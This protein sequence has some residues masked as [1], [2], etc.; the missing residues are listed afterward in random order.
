MKKGEIIKNGNVNLES[1][2]QINWDEIRQSVID[3]SN[4]WYEISGQYPGPTV[5]LN[6]I[7]N[8]IEG[9]IS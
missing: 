4:N 5:T 3:W 9:N 1:I 7:K 8:K 6:H 2:K